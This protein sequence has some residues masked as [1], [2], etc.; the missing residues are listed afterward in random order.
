MEAFGVAEK[1]FDADLGDAAFEQVT[2]GWLVFVEDFDE[3]G[4]G[5]GLR[6]DVIEDGGEN[7]RLDLEGA[8]FGDGKAEGIEDISINDVDRFV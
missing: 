5:V 2:D 1:L 3:L 8:G 4:L 6:A 7:L